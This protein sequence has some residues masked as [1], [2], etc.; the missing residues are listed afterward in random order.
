MEVEEDITGVTWSPKAIV[1]K[2]ETILYLLETQ[3]QHWTDIWRDNLRH[4]LLG[5]IDHPTKVQL[6]SRRLGVRKWNFH[7]NVNYITYRFKDGK[8]QILTYGPHKHRKQGF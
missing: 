6:V 8:W 3:G 2:N 1:H 4:E 7:K 5:I